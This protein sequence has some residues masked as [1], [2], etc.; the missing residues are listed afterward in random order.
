MILIRIVS[1]EVVEER[2]GVKEVI[3]GEE[4]IFLVRWM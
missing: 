3:T 2:V 1:R 4:I